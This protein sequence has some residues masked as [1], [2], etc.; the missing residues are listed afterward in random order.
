VST[1]LAMST[2]VLT[3]ET[4]KETSSGLVKDYREM[5]RWRELIMSLPLS[6]TIASTYD[7]L[8]TGPGRFIWKCHHDPII[9]WARTSVVAKKSRGAPFYWAM[10]LSIS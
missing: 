9:F 7:S 5:Q 1:A 8:S 2:M 4:W 3:A 10:F 6:T